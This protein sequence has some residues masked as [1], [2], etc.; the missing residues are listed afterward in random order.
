MLVNI[1]K[2]KMILLLF[3]VVFQSAQAQVWTLKQCIDTAQINNKY[4]QISS[5]NV[6]IGEQK[7]KEATANLIP[8]VNIVG[9]YRYYT[10]QPYQLMPMSAFGGP[11][12]QFKETQFGV[13]HNINANLQLA[14][15]LYNSQIYGAIQTTKVAS[16]LSE[17][18]YKKTEEQVFFEISNLYYNLQI[19]HHQLSF[20]DSN[21]INSKK[22]LKNMQLLKEQSL[23]KMTDVEKV[24]LQY[25]QLLT[26]KELIKSRYEQTLNAL[27]FTMGVPIIRVVDIDPAINFQNGIDYISRTTIDINIA[28]TQFRFLST[29]LKTLKRS[30]LPSINLYGTYG[31]T[32]FG[33]NESPNDFLKFFPIGFV[34]VQLS[35]P[36]FNGTVT[37]RKINQKKIE[38]QNG[39]L[40]MNLITEQNAMLVK[41]TM[42]QRIVAQQTVINTLSQIQLAQSIYDQTVLQQKQGIATLTDV[43]LADNILR[44]A[45]Q[46]YLSTVVDY[47][48]AD[49]DL[50]KLTGNINTI[51][52]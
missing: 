18:Q 2:H 37:K 3:I 13:P 47:L 48:K 44:E 36:L 26:Q 39:E 51:K 52:N 41:N 50:K 40:R 20:I 16:E 8:K 31:T 7:H 4:L 35:V 45:Q 32:G 30:R 24:Q 38:L 28:Q 27:K 21:L 33:Y 46:A 19:M 29:E 10:D 43:L 11:V 6:L 17:L 12:G 1:H 25:E 22:L 15:P 49:L 14:I 23:V 34:G 42:R 9:D 5:N